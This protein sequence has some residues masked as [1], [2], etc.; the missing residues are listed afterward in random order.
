MEQ[1][2]SLPNQFWTN[3]NQIKNNE[4]I[5]ISKKWI[6]NP[7]EALFITVCVYKWEDPRNSVEAFKKIVLLIA[8]YP[9]PGGCRVYIY[10]QTIPT[11]ISLIKQIFPQPLPSHS[12]SGR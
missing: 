10:Q 8:I 3:S 5:I 7:F 2:H 1:D 11:R 9:G 4:E 12:I 6:I